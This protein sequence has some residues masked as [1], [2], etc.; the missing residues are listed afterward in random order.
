VGN[1]EGTLRFRVRFNRTDVDQYLVGTWDGAQG[2]RIWLDGAFSHLRIGG[3][4]TPGVYTE[5]DLGNP[6]TGTDY[7]IVIGWFFSGGLWRWNTFQNGAGGWSGAGGWNPWAAGTSPLSVGRAVDGSM[8]LDGQ[9]SELGYWGHLLSAD[10]MKALQGAVGVSAPDSSWRIPGGLG[11][12]WPL[13]GD[14]LDYSDGVGAGPAPLT[15]YGAAAFA[16]V[17][18]ASVF[19]IPGG[20]A[21]LALQSAAYSGG[22]V[23]LTF[24]RA[25][26]DSAQARTVAQ[27]QLT[28]PGGAPAVAVTD[29]QVAGSTVSLGLSGDVRD[30]GSY[31]VTIVDADVVRA[32][33]DE[34]GNAAGAEVGFDIDP[35]PFAVASAERVNSTRVRV[36]F[37]RSVKQSNPAAG[38]DALNPAN[39]S[40]A[41]PAAAVLGV[42]GV[43]GSTVELITAPRGAGQP[44]VTVSN[45]V[46]L[47]G[48]PI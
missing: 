2:F 18:G 22:R 39:Y 47:Q 6:A 30:G 48:D 25:V 23:V 14:L 12:Y 38:D 13:S 24:D 36:R 34:G 33:A 31:L 10:E 41:G 32:A 9:L 35:V 16:N 1:V 5:L 8:P 20:T 43:D 42:Q 3:R 4:Q 37:S 27:Y 29:A 45:V 7:D 21:L 46:D 44:R 40:I 15:G 28:P 26:L 11:P 17:G 19:G